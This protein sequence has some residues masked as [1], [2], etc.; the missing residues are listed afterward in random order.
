MYDL[1]LFKPP[2]SRFVSFFENKSSIKPFI[3]CPNSGPYPYHQ[4]FFIFGSRSESTYLGQTISSRPNRPCVRP[5]PLDF[6]PPC[7][8]S[9]IPKHEIMSFTMTVPASHALTGPRL[10]GLSEHRNSLQVEAESCLLRAAAL[11]L[12]QH[13]L[14]VSVP[15]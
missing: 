4:S 2:R 5:M 1:V 15:S 11:R 13:R 3:C 9:L 8:A 14:R 10:R 12:P 6:T 7:G